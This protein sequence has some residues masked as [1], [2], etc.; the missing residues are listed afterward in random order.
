LNS[1]SS[2]P[3]LKLYK[4]KTVLDVN[5][6]TPT[7]H[8]LVLINNNTLQ[9][10]INLINN[11]LIYHNNKFHYYFIDQSYKGKLFNKTYRSL[12]NKERQLIYSEVNSKLSFINTPTQ[13]DSIDGKNV[14]V[15][16]SKYNEIFFKYGVKIKF[17]VK[18]LAYMDLIKSILVD[19]KYDEYNLKTI[20]IDADSWVKNV[21]A[22]M[23]Q[24]MVLNNPVFII[25][26]A[27]HKFFKKFQELGDINILIYGGNTMIR[28]NPS[29]CDDKSYT[30]LRRELIKIAPDMNITDNDKDLD[31]QIEVQEIR[32]D[33]LGKFL[34]TFGFTGNHPDDPQDEDE[35]VSEG[36]NDEEFQ[37]AITSRIDELVNSPEAKT[38][39]T[40]ELKD[41]LE[42]VLVNDEKLLKEIYTLNQEKK[43]GRTPQSLKRD[44]EL[45]ENQKNI[46]L[47]KMTLD[48]ARNIKLKE[49]FIPSIDVTSNVNT[50]NKNMT[51][52]KYPFFEKSYNENLYHAD[53][54]NT[55]TCLNDKGLPV[56]VRKIDVED[57]SDE[58]N[59]RETFSVELEDSNRVRHKLKFDMPKFIDDKFL[60]LNG[61]KKII[62][63]QLFSKP[64]I[65]IG[66]DKVQVCSNYKKIFIMRYGNKVSSKIE[67]FK[68]VISIPRSGV[69]IKY[70]NNANNN[71]KYKSLLEYDELSK[72]ISYIK[73]SNC[74]FYFDQNE[75]HDLLVKYKTKL[76]EDEFC[77]GFF[78][79]PRSPIIMNYSTQRMG[80]FDI[81]DFIMSVSSGEAFKEFEDT[82]AGKKFSYTRAYIM[83]KNV[84][85][86]LLLGYV[87]GLTS[88]LKK[89]NIKHQFVDKRPKLADNENSIQFSDGYLVYDVNPFEN[90]LLMNAFVD[91]PTKAFEYTDFDDKETYLTIFDTMFN[92]KIIGNAFDNFYEFLIDPITKEV[93]ED[94]N[95]PTDFVSLMLFANALLSDNSYINEKDMSLYRIRSNEV[96]S[97]ILYQGIAQQYSRYKATANNNNPVR[98]S[99]PRD[100]VTKELLMGQTIEDYSTL[101]PIVEFFVVPL[102]SDI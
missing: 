71:S 47:G 97:A 68:K 100:Y 74:E 53:V 15:D 38:Q 4:Q 45:R 41:K 72:Y 101:N 79:N 67:R 65:K 14:Y 63:K 61:N 44:I 82:K 21:R 102:C 10:S 76:K 16:L 84:P 98:I 12:V 5:P 6:K 94:L 95:Y 3:H 81:V 7:L 87:E 80:N 13:L 30:V 69:I 73:I 26:Y 75:V 25:Y 35:E 57:S 91:V 70:G 60:Y 58:L 78:I 50:I 56:F 2:T 36:D 89:A 27:M 20:C 39:T 86:V 43:V 99:L 92:T 51:G 54:A 64:V 23:K 34:Y 77:I 1:V 59:Y 88:V 49:S 48:E 29:L 24:K 8:S 85:L 66:P 19:S 28:V 37:E 55:L 62:N 46:M 22:S 96:V 40:K 33:L 93:L 17:N 18:I 83:K 90:S 31:R 52:I 42:N 9:S 32:D 11:P